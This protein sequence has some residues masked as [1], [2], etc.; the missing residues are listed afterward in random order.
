M[1]GNGRGSKEGLTK[2]YS[3]TSLYDGPFLIESVSKATYEALL[4]I[5]NIT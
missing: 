3:M 2:I 5:P 1:T 4:M